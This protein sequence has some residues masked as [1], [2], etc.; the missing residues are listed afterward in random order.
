MPAGYSPSSWEGTPKAFVA[1]LV[2]WLALLFA[3]F[4]LFAPHNL[5]SAIMLILSA[6]AVAGAVAT[7]LELEQGFGSVVHIS[8]EPMREAVKI[9]QAQH[10]LPIPNRDLYGLIADIWIYQTRCWTTGGRRCALGKRAED[11]AHPFARTRHTPACKHSF[12]PG[13]AWQQ[14]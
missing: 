9:M 6:L 13:A 10:F 5:T 1:L 4:G 11:A 14:P 7:F 2:F 8:P 3:S 12:A